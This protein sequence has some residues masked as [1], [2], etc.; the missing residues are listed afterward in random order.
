MSTDNWHYPRTDFAKEVY[1]M[2][3][4]HHA[5]GVSIFGPRRTG[6]TEFL[7]C[8][9]KP[10]AE[11]RKHRVIYVNFWQRRN[12]PLH[13][14][15]DT[16]AGTLHASSRWS[17]KRAKARVGINAPFATAG[18]DMQW[19]KQQ[20]GMPEDPLLR[21]DWYFEQLARGSKPI[22]LLFD[23]FQE[24]ARAETSSQVVV[25]ALR[26]SLDTRRS[27]LSAVFTGSSEAELQGMFSSKEAP[28][29]QYA[30][31]LDLPRMD[32]QFIA[33]QIK[34]H[35]CN[36]GRES[37][38]R[39][40]DVLRV[41]EHFGHNLEL[42]RNCLIFLARFPDLTEAQAID[43]VEN[44]H[45]ERD[46]IRQWDVLNLAQRIIVRM[47]AADVRK[48][49]SKQ[50]TAFIKK[51]TGK[52]RLSETAESDSSARQGALRHLENIGMVEQRQKNWQLSD[53]WF[54]RWVR[55]RPPE[56]FQA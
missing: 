3:I 40:Q 7:L 46:Y 13:L 19:G 31:H 20:Q 52:E 48:I 22:L 35:Q 4:E 49:Y 27:K 25:A 53:A 21:L 10:Y 8:D 54:A 33:H 30:M 36:R 29:Y 44:E 39:P 15:L 5:G 6:K 47:L 43:K 42:F 26:T 24:L 14:L 18:I 12:A 2:L 55:N 32:R 23:E 45:A 17:T 16:L 37:R 9:L 11:A 51:L 56:D 28:F 1:S 41:L 50:G 38:L 34:I